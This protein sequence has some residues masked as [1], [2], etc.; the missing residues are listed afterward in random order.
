M[1]GEWINTETKE[2]VKAGHIKPIGDNWKAIVPAH[3]FCYPG[4]SFYDFTGDWADD[5]NKQIQDWLKKTW[6]YSVT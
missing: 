3:R 2:T 5:A 4:Y 1:I 6:S